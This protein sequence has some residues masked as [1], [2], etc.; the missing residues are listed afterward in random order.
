MQR[1]FL[2]PRI[3]HIPILAYLPDTVIKNPAGAGELRF[4]K[5]RCLFCHHTGPF[6]YCPFGVG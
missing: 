3:G 4:S 2:K 1:G 5:L 6:Q